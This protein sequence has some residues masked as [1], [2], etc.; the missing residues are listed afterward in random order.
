[1]Q[2]NSKIYVAGHTGLAG[3]AI[4]RELSR[5]GYKNQVIRTSRELDLR[6]SE[7]VE[8][9]FRSEKPEYVFLAA[10]YVGGIKAN[11]D[12]PANFLMFNLKIQNN[13]INA[14]KQ[15]GVKK[16]L[17]L[18]SSC[19]YPKLTPQP[20]REEYLLTAQLESTNQWYAVAKIAG[21]ELC[22]QY[23]KQYGC[24]FIAV[25]PTNLYGPNDNYNLESSHVLPGLIRRFHNAKVSCQEAVTCWGSGKPLREFL[26]SDDL[27]RAV[28]YVM[29]NYSSDEI[30]NI[31]SGTEI[32]IKEL[33]H[34]IAKVVGF[35][36]LIKWDETKPDGTPR[37]FLDC[38][39]LQ[40]L[41]WRPSISLEN[42]I[43]TTYEDFVQNHSIYANC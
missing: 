30:I 31:G 29:Y 7:A 21:I 12:Y 4:C 11:S 41:G 5:L 24:D 28:V 32:S 42:G 33:S 39:K 22:K 43:K 19:V 27:G 17:F 23:R 25:M 15:F 1:M 8:S 36:G 18:G 37:K 38:S 35:E 40:R 16:L 9:F 26:H 6:D 3:S 13:V 10:G 34:L 20:I 14:S 2:H